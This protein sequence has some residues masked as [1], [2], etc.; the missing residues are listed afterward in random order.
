MNEHLAFGQ[1]HLC[2]S[3]THPTGTRT[4]L[5]DVTLRW[6]MGEAAQ[7]VYLIIMSM[8]ICSYMSPLKAISDQQI[9]VQI[10]G[11]NHTNKI[12]ISRSSKKPAPAAAENRR[13]GPAEWLK[14]HNI[15]RKRTHSLSPFTFSYKN[16]QL[17]LNQ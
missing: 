2:M 7:Y 11:S 8:I 13:A 4:K 12:P 5:A 15:T 16:Q 6:R 17:Y 1:G 10:D 14:N 9:R 3:D